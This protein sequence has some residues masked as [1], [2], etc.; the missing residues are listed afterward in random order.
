MQFWWNLQPT[1]KDG[2]GA[3]VDWSPREANREADALAI[4][5]LSLFTPDF[6][7]HVS[8]HQLQWSVLTE[9]LASGREA[10]DA[11]RTAKA[12]GFR[13]QKRRR[14]RPEERLKAVDPWSLYV[15][16]ELGLSSTWLSPFCT[17]TLLFRLLSDGSSLSI[18]T[19]LA[20]LFVVSVT[21]TQFSGLLFSC[22]V[23]DAS[24][25]PLL[26]LAISA[27]WYFKSDV[28]SY[29]CS[30]PSSHLHRRSPRMTASCPR[31]PGSW[32]EHHYS[33]RAVSWTASSRSLT[34]PS[35]ASRHCTCTRRRVRHF[36]SQ[37]VWSRGYRL[38]LVRGCSSSSKT[39]TLHVCV[40]RTMVQV[41]RVRRVLSWTPV[42]FIPVKW[43]HASTSH[44]G[45]R[46]CWWIPAR[47]TVFFVPTSALF[48]TSEFHGMC[49][50]V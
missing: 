25:F 15:G 39:S 20:D 19:S 45:V 10:E 43:V 2:L 11:H 14:R 23:I 21:G 6:G 18:S 27:V 16:Q 38:P 5:E 24:L 48:L 35:G 42:P 40:T 36:S 31:F 22:A 4:G 28:G 50:A 34:T 37:T 33:K 3:S 7:I 44:S 30:Q 8:L 49:P 46:G 1:P 41:R 32:V 13:N 12:A 47:G 9:A 29:W 17:L 26:R